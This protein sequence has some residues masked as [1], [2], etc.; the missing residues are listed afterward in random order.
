MLLD[1]AIL[2]HQ[3]GEFA[4]ARA[5]Y[6][7]ILEQEPANP[8]ALHLLGVL[9]H[10]AGDPRR[11]AGLIRQA[12]ERAPNVA[13]YHANLGEALRAD[14][15]AE[16]AIREY[17]V[18]LRLDPRFAPAQG[19]IGAALLSLGRVP[20]AIASLRS[21]VALDPALAEAY[22]NLGEALRMQGGLT[23][24]SECFEQAVSA[25]PD[26]PEAHVNL[27]NTLKACGQALRALA[28]YREALRLRPGLAPA[29]LNLANLLIEQGQLGEAR[30][31]YHQA[32]RLQYGGAL[33]NAA[34]FRP[35]DSS[36]DAPRQGVIETT[37]FELRNRA[38]HIEHLIETGKLDASFTGLAG[39]YRS[40]LAELDGRAPAN[41]TIR[42]QPAQ[43]KRL[44]P[45]HHQVIRYADAEPVV[46]FAVNPHLD[47]DRLERAYLASPVAVTWFDNFLSADA[48]R[49]LYDFC[50]D[51]TIFFG[52]DRAGT[53][54][55]Y[56]G[57]GFDCSLLFQ[58]VE[59]LKQRFPRILSSQVLRNIWVY[60]YPQEGRGVNL[61]TDNGSVTFN[62][63][64]TPDEA[65]L[66]P[67]GSGLIVYPKEQPLTENWAEINKKK[68]EPG[69]QQEIRNFLG[70]VEPIRIAYRANRAVLFHSNL[71][72]Q[73]DYFRFQDGY[74]NRRMN[75]TLLFGDRGTD[76]RMRYLA[77]Q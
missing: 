50:L 3:A 74:R 77:A 72:H 38:E 20:E 46:P 69:V 57:A 48:L 22:L 12:I 41:E 54:Q 32:F 52:R 63:W 66:I 64:I 5:L 2:L 24:A 70:A 17:S 73:S 28:H 13:I 26:F 49:G 19:G 67:E 11:G 33:W 56:V 36:V 1:E 62:F 30:A 60:R 8:D 51:S 14:G 53:L 6:G 4:R 71:F 55:S 43:A 39:I 47:F 76:V 45:F 31:H 35:A 34:G 16:A 29:H 18:A 7:R 37:L 42:L 10:Q 27:A 75:V 65:N 40:L 58:I 25:K 23:E 59:E 61:H 15:Q 21:A 68:D 44:L 9:A